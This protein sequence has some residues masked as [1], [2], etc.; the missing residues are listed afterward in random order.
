MVAADRGGAGDARNAGFFERLARRRLMRI[1]A[2]DQ[3]AFRNDPAAR[4]A[5][6]DEQGAK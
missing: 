6:G 4:V 2:A 1:E 5:R 3:I